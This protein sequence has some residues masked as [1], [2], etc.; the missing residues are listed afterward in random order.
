MTRIGRRAFVAAIALVGPL[1]RASSRAQAFSLDDFLAL[2]SRL[3]GHR[4][5]ER[6]TGAVILKNLLGTPANPAR[7]LRPDPALERDIIVAWYTG[8]QDVRGE[9][10]TVTHA[11]ALQWRTLGMLAPGTCIGRFGAWTNPPR[12]AQR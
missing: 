3:T 10:R 5:L 12:A 8:V 11:G 4:N 1:F 2:S 9:S 6:E 7:L